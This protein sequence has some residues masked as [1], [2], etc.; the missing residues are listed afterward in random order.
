MGRMKMTH[1]GD[2]GDGSSPVGSRGK[3]LVGGLGDFVPQ[4]LT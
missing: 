2:L 1:A 3:V 4:K